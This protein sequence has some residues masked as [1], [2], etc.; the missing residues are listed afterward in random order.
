MGKPRRSIAARR[1]WE[2]EMWKQLRRW[3]SL[4][5]WVRQMARL[6][7]HGAPVRYDPKRKGLYVEPPV[8]LAEWRRNVAKAQRG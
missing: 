6:P 1:Y 2:D 7:Y 8:S 3:L 4:R 5:A